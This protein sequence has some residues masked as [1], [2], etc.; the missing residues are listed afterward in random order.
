[1][2]DPNCL[3]HNRVA[4]SKRYLMY[5]VC[6]N[7][8]PQPPWN[9]TSCSELF[10][11]Y[12]NFYFF[13]FLFFFKFLSQRF[14]CGILWSTNSWP[15]SCNS[16]LHIRTMQIFRL[17]WNWSELECKPSRDVKHS[18]KGPLRRS[19]LLW[20][21]SLWTDLNSVSVT[22]PLFGWSYRLVTAV[23]RE[24]QRLPVH[25]PIG[26]WSCRAC[27]TVSSPGRGWLSANLN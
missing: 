17:L 14:K 26:W 10:L 5:L 4:S 12:Y 24:K 1:M 11:Q 22:E 8:P 13:F 21:D 25:T 3:A 20:G 23:N 9:K 18:I 19:F 7:C 16:S 15:P 2:N 6:F 27:L